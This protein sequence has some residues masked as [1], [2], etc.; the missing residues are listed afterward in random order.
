VSVLTHCH[1]CSSTWDTF[2]GGMSHGR[3]NIIGFRFRT[4]IL[5]ISIAGAPP[6]LAGCCVPMAWPPAYGVS[7]PAANTTADDTKEQLFLF[8][9]MVL[10]GVVAER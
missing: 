8:E 2:D 1:T 9:R 10:S 6:S 4:G 3:T 7:R 5:L